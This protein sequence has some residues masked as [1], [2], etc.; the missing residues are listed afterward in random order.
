MSFA[1]TAAARGRALHHVETAAVRWRALK[2]FNQSL[3]AGAD[4]EGQCWPEGD[5]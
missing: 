4:F 1:E 2:M 3:A 5:I